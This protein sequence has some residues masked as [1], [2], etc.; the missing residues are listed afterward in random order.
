[1]VGDTP[2]PSPSPAVCPTTPGRL[3]NEQI[4]DIIINEEFERFVIDIPSLESLG[5]RFTGIAGYEL[6]Y[7]APEE[8]CIWIFTPYSQILQENTL[9]IHG[10]YILQVS[11]L[12]NAHPLTLRL[13]LAQPGHSTL[14]T[15]DSS[16][17]TQQ[18]RSGIVDP[19][20]AVSG[21]EDN[22]ESIQQYQSDPL[23]RFNISNEQIDRFTM[24][25]IELQ[26]ILK[27]T[28]ILLV[29]ATSEQ[30]KEEIEQQ[31]DS[32]IVSVIISNQLS[33]DEYQDILTL[34]QSDSEVAEL[35]KAA[36]QRLRI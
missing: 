24:I 15:S 11:P 33:L 23:T 6:N 28:E 1:M 10:S 8:L 29:Q 21:D 27:S 3:I 18:S 26:P 19:S 35:V 7:L 13:E 30:M 9:P 14:V 4:Q 22:T 34:T 31:F 20:E 17:T 12:H 32:E 16:A 2:I 25:T 36:T 5:Y